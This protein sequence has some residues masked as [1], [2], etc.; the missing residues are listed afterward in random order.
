MVG[1]RGVNAFGSGR[2]NDDSNPY[3]PKPA[4]F[5]FQDATNKAMEDQR[6]THIKNKLIN[7]VKGNELESYRKSEDDL[8]SI[9][10]KKVKEFY[11]QQNQALNDWLEVDSVV[12]S[13]AD[14]ILESFDPDRDH[15]GLLEHGGALQA[16]GEDVEAFLPKEEREKRSKAERSAKKAINVRCPA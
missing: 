9:E 14:D 5:R 3:R 4:V 16:Q 13:I 6:R 11:K 10:N 1:R 12:R 8:K 2:K 7:A 15:D